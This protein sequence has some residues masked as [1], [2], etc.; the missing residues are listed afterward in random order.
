VDV[1]SKR[2]ELASIVNSAVNYN[3][4]AS[5]QVSPQSGGAI[6]YIQTTSGVKYAIDTRLPIQANPTGIQQANGQ[7]EY[8]YGLMQ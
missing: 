6:Y 7:V 5:I 3:G 1:G 8:F 2:A 4:Q